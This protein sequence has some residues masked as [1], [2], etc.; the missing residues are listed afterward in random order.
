M[1]NPSRLPFNEGIKYYQN[2]MGLSVWKNE[3]A[4]GEPLAFV[5]SAMLDVKGCMW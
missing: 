1:L 4:T 2:D 5:L 3:V